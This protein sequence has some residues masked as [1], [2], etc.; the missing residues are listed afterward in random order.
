MRLTCCAGNLI[1]SITRSFTA[2]CMC[3]LEL[4]DNEIIFEWFVA[5]SLIGGLF[6]PLLYNYDLE[7]IPSHVHRQEFFYGCVEE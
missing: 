2:Q 3:R 5:N 6:A 1:G 7:A 4:F